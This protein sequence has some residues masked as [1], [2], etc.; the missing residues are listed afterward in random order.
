MLQCWQKCCSKMGH[1]IQCLLQFSRHRINNIDAAPIS[2]YKHCCAWQQTAV[3]STYKQ[4]Q[5]C[6]YTEVIVCVCGWSVSDCVLIW[7]AHVVG[8]QGTFALET[9][10]ILSLFILRYSIL[11]TRNDYESECVGWIW[12]DKLFLIQQDLRLHMPVEITIY[13][14]MFEVHNWQVWKMY[15]IL[16]KLKYAWDLIS[17]GKADSQVFP[18]P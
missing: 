17:S 12:L 3:F 13:A 8:G 2:Q 4:V 5:L 9:L 1:I 6:S 7:S 16:W 11:Y 10:H 18:A 14:A 15:G